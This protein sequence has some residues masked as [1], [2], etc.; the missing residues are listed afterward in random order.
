[1]SDLLIRAAD[2]ICDVNEYGDC[3]PHQGFARGDDMHCRFGVPA[4]ERLRAAGL[5]TEPEEDAP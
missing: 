3:T 2:L 5:L 1:M 4:A